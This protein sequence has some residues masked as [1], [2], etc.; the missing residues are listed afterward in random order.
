MTSF[1]PW[2]SPASHL[3]LAHH[4]LAVGPVL[5]GDNHTGP[6][7]P[8]GTERAHGA[9]RATAALA[10]AE[11]RSTRS[12]ARASMA[13]SDPITPGR[14]PA[15]GTAASAPAWAS[16]AAPG[17]TIGGGV[18]RRARRQ[19]GGEELA[20]EGLGP[21]RV[22]VGHVAVGDVGEG[23]GAAV[24]RSTKPASDAH[25]VEGA[26]LGPEPAL[27]R[28]PSEPVARVPDLAGHRQAGCRST[29]S[30]PPL[31]RARRP[32]RRR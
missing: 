9:P 23:G 10:S 16:W 1:T 12:A 21:H 3:L 7:E 22:L 19:V 27:G 31:R 2:C 30:A 8:A 25:A 4:L 24:G 29:P 26:G 11:Q 18:A 13:W 15:A 32:A 6:H 20:E 17:M 28:V 5:A 14:A